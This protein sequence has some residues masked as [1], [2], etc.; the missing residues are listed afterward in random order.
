MT[1]TR[2]FAPRDQRRVGGQSTDH[3]QRARLPGTDI[4]VDAVSLV[5][6]LAVFFA[7]PRHFVQGLL[8][9][10]VK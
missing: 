3:V 5:I 7:F 9:G 4:S 10:W 8:A 2:R 1:R 6:P